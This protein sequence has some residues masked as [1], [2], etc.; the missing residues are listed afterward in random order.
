M[1]GLRR[2]EQE[3]EGTRASPNE[4]EKEAGAAPSAGCIA[5]A[6]APVGRRSTV[7]MR[8]RLLAGSG[9]AVSE[10]RSGWLDGSGKI[11]RAHV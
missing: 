6:S 11:G 3:A 7:R 8:G 9:S 2:W 4:K 5:A 10:V 1:E